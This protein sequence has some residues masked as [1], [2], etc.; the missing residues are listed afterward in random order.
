MG[1]IGKSKAIG[2]K[3][4]PI[5]RHS[6]FVGNSFCRMANWVEFATLHSEEPMADIEHTSIRAVNMAAS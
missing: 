4:L 5:S 2:P 3:R 1:T 6:F